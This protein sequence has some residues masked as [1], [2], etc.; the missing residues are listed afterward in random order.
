MTLDTYL[1]PDVLPRRHGLVIGIAV[2]MMVTGLLSSL[3]KPAEAVTGGLNAEEPWSV[4]LVDR[5]FWRLF[6][7]K[8]KPLHSQ[9]C[10]GSLVARDWVLT[11][12][13]CVDEMH[14]SV[15]IAVIGRGDLEGSAGL[16]SEIA[17]SSDGSK[18]IFMHPCYTPGLS[19]D[20]V[21]H[22]HT[23]V[24][25]ANEN[26]DVALVRL[27][28]PVP[29]S[30]RVLPLAPKGV[31]HIGQPVTLYGYGLLEISTATQARHLKRTPD[32]AYTS[33]G[34]CRN[35]AGN[36]Y[37][38]LLCFGDRGNPAVEVNRG[39]SGAPWTYIAKGDRVQI[40]VHVGDN[41]PAELG[42]DMVDRGYGGVNEPWTWVR[43]TAGL[44]KARPNSII[45][46][47]ETGNAWLVGADGFRRPVPTG[48]DYLCFT[49]K[50]TPSAN[51]Y[52]SQISQIPEAP[53]EPARCTPEPST[54]GP[55]TPG[56]GGGGQRDLVFV[57][58]TTGSMGDDIDAVKR[59]ATNVVNKLSGNFRVALVDYKDR[60][61][62]GGDG[63]DYPSRLVLGFSS[64]KG[65]IVNAINSLGATGGGDWPE[66]AYS[67]LMRA[68]SLSWRAAAARSI[69]WMG[70]A[71]PK[72]P[73]PITNFTKATVINAARA[74]K[75][76]FLPAGAAP[77]GPSAAPRLSAAEAPSA[78]V[79]ESRTLAVA[80]E[81]EL[82]T[83]VGDD[84]EFANPVLIFAVEVGG[85]GGE[86]YKE[87]P[88][89]TGGKHFAARDASEVVDALTDA[90]EAAVG[91][92]PV[93]FA[94]AAQVGTSSLRA[95][96]RPVDSETEG[97]VRGL[98]RGKPVPAA[99]VDEAGLTTIADEQ[100]LVVRFTFEGARWELRYRM[101]R[102]GQEGSVEL[103]G[104]SGC[105]SGVG[106]GLVGAEA[107][108]APGLSTAIPLLT[109]SLPAITAHAAATA[110]VAATTTTTLLG[111]TTTT[112]SATT[113]TTAPV[114][115][116]S[117]V[118]STG[119][120]PPAVTETASSTPSPLPL[121][122][123]PTVT[124]TG[125]P[126]TGDR[127][128]LIDSY[129]LST[130]SEAERAQIQAALSKARE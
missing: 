130:L 31:N 119:S 30:H 58:D 80:A 125:T 91:L 103:C 101:A 22:C 83:E 13:H 100:A 15:D 6:D 26:W 9:F 28:T 39:D 95:F 79:A 128:S 124:P 53:G 11:A 33:D 17:V 129:D 41:S 86:A 12:A 62:A 38:Y 96:G 45:R 106:A 127:P 59:S 76:V 47:V 97:V 1:G 43:D 66:T 25:G 75:A 51:L 114:A 71:P 73:E 2:M 44:L 42:V 85:N 27:K 32:G 20:A 122:S 115:P 104:P 81:E 84:E 5:D 65:A 7:D 63:G 54:P 36:L 24:V 56:P 46:N 49:G 61:S 67:G 60:P 14:A 82:G 4:L 92:E 120:S 37:P 23:G 105:E 3:A 108:N 99:P 107:E 98:L 78:T 113:T 118:A 50:G 87:I 90:I 21:I 48:G 74:K 52:F 88:A 55:G 89:E 111:M 29:V 102:R 110:V 35:T 94:L 123:P 112:L 109:A 18:Q 68:L 69:I 64:D 19:F 8:P 126:P 93:T 121:E 117:P 40:A 70:D 10:S 16:E 34:W 116:S 72:D 57:I 77:E